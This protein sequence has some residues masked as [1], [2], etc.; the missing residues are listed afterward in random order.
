M[1]LSV[2]LALLLALWQQNWLNALAIFAILILI[3]LPWLIGK[4]YKISVPVEFEVTAVIFVYSSI[5]LGSFYE[6]YEKFWWWDVHLHLASGF[7]IGIFGF[8]VLYLLNYSKDI[9]L[10]MKAGFVALFAFAFSVTAG[11]FWEFLEY[12]GDF[13]F[14]STMQN[15]S[16]TDTMWDLIMDAI[17][18][19]I[20]SALG[21]LWMKERINFFIFDN[22]LKKFVQRENKNIIK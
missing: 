4:R 6:Y 8:M 7:L 18:A 5:F 11:V 20:I 1:K 9:R 19:F 22:T 15:N 13:I 3:S 12:T 2:V 16:L 17:G 14:N 10:N 21:Y